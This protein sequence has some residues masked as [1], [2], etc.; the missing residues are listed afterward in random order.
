MDNTQNASDILGKQVV[1]GFFI[2]CGILVLLALLVMGLVFLIAS[3]KRIEDPEIQNQEYMVYL[4]KGYI[5]R[6]CYGFCVAIDTLLLTIEIAA[7]AT[8]TFIAVIPGTPSY[9]VA[10]LLIATVIASNFRSVLDLKH[11]RAAY[12]R[13][14]RIL[15]FAVDDYRISN[16][17]WEAQKK[18]HDA[19]VRAQKIIE[20]LYE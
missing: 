6:F 8:G 1:I 9:L 14:F 17:D 11:G 12:A 4:K 18:L 19:N 16:H 7:T 13:A 10:I 3:L 15:E 5:L 2:I 20:D